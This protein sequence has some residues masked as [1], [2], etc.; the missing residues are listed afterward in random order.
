MCFIFSLLVKRFQL[1]CICR[2]ER[3]SEDWW[4]IMV[5]C[6]CSVYGGELNKYTHQLT[7]TL[8]IG[9]IIPE[10]FFVLEM[11]SEGP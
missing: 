9:I 1:L 6:S 2:N 10:L 4:V 11:I 7:E 8:N 5:M 3:K